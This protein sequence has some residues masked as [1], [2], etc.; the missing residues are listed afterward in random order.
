MDLSIITGSFNGLTDIQK[1]AFEKSIKEADVNRDNVLDK[2]EFREAT[3]KFSKTDEFKSLSAENKKL[4][5]EKL[6]A[7]TLWAQQG[8]SAVTNYDGMQKQV[9]YYEKLLKDPAKNKDKDGKPLVTEEQ[10]KFAKENGFGDIDG[11]KGIDGNELAV[12][13][14]NGDK[15]IDSKDGDINQDGLVN[16]EDRGVNLSKSNKNGSG[17]GFDLKKFAEYF[18]KIIEIWSP[19]AAAVQIPAPQV[20][21]ATS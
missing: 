1:K 17:G 19:K 2:K 3:E 14:I 18:Q 6:D 7:D 15:K 12:A 8:A 9:E 20:K 16:K 11:K 5:T 21:P 4:F 13:N 10:L